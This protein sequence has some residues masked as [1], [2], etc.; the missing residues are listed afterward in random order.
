MTSGQILF[1]LEHVTQRFRLPQGDVTV[2]KDVSFKAREG[3]FIAI[4]GPSGAGKS[5]ILRIINGLLRPSEGKVIYKE[6]PLVSTNLEAAMVFQNFALLPWLTVAENIELGL[7]PRGLDRAARRKRAAFYIAK[8]GLEGY[9]EAYPRELSGG[10]KQRVGLA[11]AL[12]VE[13]EI[14]LMDE[15][16]SSLDAL[17]SINLRDELLDIW[18]DR[19]FPV[20]T[21]VMVTHLIEE[22]IELADRVLVLSSKPGQI[23]GDLTIDLP[24]PRRKRDKAF[25][26]YVDKIFSLIA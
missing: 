3:E 8:V 21:V 18:A 1:E 17:T 19:D 10:M 23:A 7:E 2:L 26:E 15:P 11:R 20:N 6:K 13:P 12:A 24:R 22:A 5:T 16:F 14:L 4:V 25:S 9:E